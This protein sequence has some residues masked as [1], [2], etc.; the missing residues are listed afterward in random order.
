MAPPTTFFPSARM[1]TGRRDKASE[2]EFGAPDRP[3]VRGGSD[4]G[5]G[6]LGRTVMLVVS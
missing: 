3:M 6:Y 2:C 4:V 5:H 1:R